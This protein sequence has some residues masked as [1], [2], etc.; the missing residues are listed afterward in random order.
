MTK[1][2]KREY[3]SRGKGLMSAT[4]PQ[5]RFILFL[6]FLL[7]VYTLLLRVFQNLALIVELPV[8]LPIALITLLLFIGIAGAVYSHKFIGPLVRI[9]RTLDQIAA[10]DCSVTLRLRESD[11][12]MLKDLVQTIT[13]L[14]ENNRNIRQNMHETASDLIQAVSR[15][16]DSIGSGAPLPEIQKQAEALLRKQ[17]LFEKALHALGK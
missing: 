2:T 1:D 5:V 9:R 17:E 3:F 16:R 13:V 4:G 15:L 11:D 8:F 10:G 6:V 12:P 14:C 7:I